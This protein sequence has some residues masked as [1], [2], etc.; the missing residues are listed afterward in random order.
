[1]INIG[2]VVCSFDAVGI[3]VISQQKFLGCIPGPF[4][5]VIMFSPCLHKVPPVT[6]LSSHIK[7]DSND[8]SC[9]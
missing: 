7:S 9:Q 6:L 8:M 3:T 5:G 2:H 1:M 4:C